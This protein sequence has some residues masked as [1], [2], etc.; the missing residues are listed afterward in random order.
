MIEKALSL[1]NRRQANL[2]PGYIARGHLILATGKACAH[3]PY[4]RA[5]IYADLTLLYT[6]GDFQPL[7]WTYPDYGEERMRSIC[8]KIRETYLFQ[9]R[10]R[11]KDNLG[12]E[13]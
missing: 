5:G 9:L 1:E 6:K 8:K 4:L 3:R 12:C 11:Q 13:L 10:E 2:D 7:A